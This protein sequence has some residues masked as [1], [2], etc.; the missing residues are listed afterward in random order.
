MVA[1][2]F[3]LISVSLCDFV[4]NWALAAGNP[5]LVDAADCR[6]RR[7]YGVGALAVSLDGQWR[8]PLTSLN[9]N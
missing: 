6:P 4:C 9:R 8:R 5:A 1:R 2:S 7:R 3:G